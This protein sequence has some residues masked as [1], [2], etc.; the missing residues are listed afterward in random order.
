MF[1]FSSRFV[2]LT[3]ALVAALSA[4]ATI[5]PAQVDF[6]YVKRQAAAKAGSPYVP[7]KDDLPSTLGALTYDDYRNI[8]FRPPQAL[9]KAE[10]LPF[11]LQFFHRGG[12]FREKVTLREFRE[13]HEQVIPFMRDFFSYDLKKDLGWLKS[14]LGYAGFRVH[15]PLNLPSVYDEVI[16][17][18]GASYFRAIGAGQIYG[19]SARGLAI[20]TGVRERPEEFPRFTDFWIGKPQRDA[21]SLTIYA[22]LEGPTVNGAYEFVVT[23]GKA[24]FVDVHAAIYFRNTNEVVGIAPLT[25]M[26]WYGENTDRPAG[27]PRPEVH[28]SDGLLIQDDGKRFWRPLDNPREALTTILPVKKLDRFGLLQRDR[29]P[30]SYE[31]LESNYQRRPSAWIEPRGEWGA[32]TVRLV[33]L[34]TGH[35]YGDNIVA[36]WTPAVLPPAGQPL[37]MHYR[38][39]WS[40][41]EGAK[42]GVARVQATHVGTLP[43]TEHG[44]LYWIDFVDEKAGSRDATMMQAEVETAEGLHVRPPVVMRY[45]EIGG[46]RVALQVE[47]DKL[48]HPLTLRCHLRSGRETIS[49]T[50]MATWQ[51]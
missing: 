38:L 32:G 8:R 4:R 19:L 30:A 23:P 16:V 35:E 37:D 51:P 28:D 2:G 43:N 5:E 21:T 14:S 39:V 31:D 46:W 9:W 44:R 20:D 24:T 42:A 15:Y 40:L 11:Q 36:F 3:L 49:E 26:F 50:W 10:G 22:L 25:S 29:L 45:P 33:E 6:E 48:G 7:P 18:L 1:R 17:F 47:A 13:G 12:L 34:P 27:Q 41:E